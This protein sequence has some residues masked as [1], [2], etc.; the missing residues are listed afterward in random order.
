MQSKHRTPERRKAGKPRV[1]KERGVRRLAGKS[2][3]PERPGKTSERDQ[4]PPIAGV[5]ASAGGLE[6]F[7]QLLRALPT[8]TG[9]AFVLVQHLEPR[10]ES[11]LAKLLS[12]ATQMPATEVKHRMRV[13]PN[14]VYVIPPNADIVVRQGV[15]H[16]VARRAP[17]G[18]HMPIDHFLRSL[19]EDQGSRAIGVILSGTASDGT[20]GL[21]AVKAE[22]GITFAQ[23]P[24]SAKYD[25]MPRSAIAAGCVDFVLPPEDIAK[26]LARIS[27]HPYIGLPHA[28]QGTPLL[29]AQEEEFGRIF[30]L[31]R[32]ISGVDFTYYKKTTIKRR[33]ARRMALHK[34]DRLS[35]YLRYLED[36]RDEL[37]ALYQDI[38]IHVTSFFREPDV[39]RALQSTFLPQIVA[40]KSPGDAVRLWVPGCSTGEEVY[41]IAIALFEALGDRANSTP[42]Q[43]FGTDIS[44]QS[45]EKARFGAYPESTLQHI[46]RE[47]LRRFFV[48]SSGQYQITATVREVCVF[49]RHDLTRDPPFSR[50]DLISC[51]NVLIYL[52]PVLQKRVLSSFH[53]ALKETGFLLLGKSETLS[54]CADL[55][56]I[57]DRNNKL[58]AK[59]ASIAE[60][61]YEWAPAAHEGRPPAQRRL[62]EAPPAFDLEKEIDRIVWDRYAHAGLLV[63][64]DL[65]I[66][67]FRGD[68]S[69]Y[70]RPAPGKATFNLLRMLREDLVYELRAAIHKVRR[71]GD[72]IRK[73]GIR[74]Q[75]EGR[76]REVSVSIQPL[77][78]PSPRK[79]FFLLLFDAGA[80]AAAPPEPSPSKSGKGEKD[81]VVRLKD[82]L[83]RTKEYLQ[84]I[85]QEQETTNEELKSANEEA[86]SSMEELQSTNEELETAKEE[87]Q[88]SNE[89]LVTLNEQ[90]QNRNSELAQLTDDLTNVLGGVN[91][92]ILMLG[93]DRR[94]RRFT[95]SAENLLHL[96]PSDIGRLL[97]HI[98]L[99]VGIP[100]LDQLIGT[101][102]ERGLDLERDVRAEDGRWYSIRLRPYRTG[103]RKI[104]GVLIAL[105]DID[106]MKKNQ[107]AVQKEERFVSAI[108]DAAGR[109]MLVTVL[110]PEGR[111]VHFNRACQ[112][113]TG[114]SLEEVKG[115]RPWDFLV[116]PEEAGGIRSAFSKVLTGT[117]NDSEI[118]W[119]AKDGSRRL[120]AWS[121]R[122]TLD[123][124]G[125]AQNVIGTGIDVSE[126]QQAQ[127]EARQSEATVRALLE[128]ATQA[129]LAVDRQGL[130]VLANATAETMFGYSR[131]EILDHPLENLIPE[132]LRGPHTGHQ[133]EYFARPHKRPMGLG[134]ELAG[135]RKDGTEFPVEVSLSHIATND[136]MLA[137]AFVTD[138]TERK[139]NEDAL[140]ESEAQARATQ[141]KLRAL[142]SGLL[143]AQE[144]ERRRVSRELHDDLNQR[145]AM[146]AID[147]GE[148]EKLVPDADGVVRAQ[149]Q[150]MQGRL[151]ALSED[152]RRTAYRLHP[153]ILEHLGLVEALESYCADFSKQ[154]KIRVAF[155]P[156]NVPKAIP[157]GIALCLYRVAQE[158]LR[159]VAKH[160]GASKALV[161]LTGAEGGIS[162]TVSDAGQG[163]DPASVKGKGGLGLVSIEERVIAV[164]GTLAIQSQPADGTQVRVRIPLPGGGG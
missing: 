75:H 86:L 113:M 163:F 156:R 159:N 17:A 60:T 120:I 162:L 83:A 25:G 54:G 4:M 70:L 71:G 76:A 146:L 127:E 73:D 158:C 3:A 124:D 36:H 56:T 105:V 61:P 164:G 6:A 46:S 12:S 78:G 39:F 20:L 31:L 14:H 151:D 133:A 128:T 43:I 13:Q 82:E 26:E 45:I 67:H 139:S 132:R 118:H 24:E 2:R 49:A 77:A 109:A 63:N 28:E 11:M 102:L 93:G 104:D 122:A 111:I 126:R 90:A 149:L 40:G 148:M 144:D 131:E 84:A 53:Y 92:P 145:L 58:F 119:L 68:T 94:I 91:I 62:E 33:I 96:L 147:M 99:G 143:E 125:R 1:A 137:V 101:V 106:E 130:V 108:L 115:K 116:A 5:G 8:D 121:N 85:I 136:G 135:L 7:T 65:Q 95:P 152:M 81:E 88:S 64:D 32:A 142:S 34:I 74:I 51:R 153:S 123:G 110:D 87:L 50:L 23:E 100:E 38:L 9:M 150:S 114:Y 48:Q 42:V 141:E 160:A 47:R 19:A 35:T 22:G 138:I 55:F 117:P 66:L 72:A 157:E 155:R 10:H 154:E 15:L 107:E 140:R 112:E 41:S 59:K 79:R 98:R 57:V 29:P 97:G 37:E 134:L 129:I 69:P 80:I 27:R 44:E 30:R 52:E 16:P 18:M 161:T 21:K 89:E 103:D